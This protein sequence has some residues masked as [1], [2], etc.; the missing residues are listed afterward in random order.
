MQKMSKKKIITLNNSAYEVLH[1]VIQMRT[2]KKKI[3][4]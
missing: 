3:A 2:E 4:I 1:T